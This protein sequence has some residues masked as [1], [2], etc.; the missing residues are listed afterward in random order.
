M[1]DNLVGILLVAVLL[2][3]D[4]SHCC[5]TRIDCESESGAKEESC[6][7]FKD[8]EE[9]RPKVLQRDYDKGLEEAILVFNRTA[10]SFKIFISSYCRMLL[11]S[12]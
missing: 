9:H 11:L 8:T 10:V 2:C 3:N 7:A 12:M 4:K 6:Q 1:S 5:Y